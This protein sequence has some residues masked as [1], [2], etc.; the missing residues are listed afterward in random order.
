MKV[1]MIPFG[2]DK[3]PVRGHYNDAGADVFALKDVLVPAGATVNIGLGFGIEV[4][5]GMMAVVF[6]RS[7]MAAKGVA[8]EMPP[9]DSG[10]R[11]EIHA[12]MTNHSDRPYQINRGD[13]IGQLVVMPV[14]YVEYVDELGD[15]RKTGAF[16]STGR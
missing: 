7:S 16:G 5:D 15:E 12:I 10:Y 4:P 14:I 9:I 11:G 6:S 2:A 13:K 3:A 1:K 8:C